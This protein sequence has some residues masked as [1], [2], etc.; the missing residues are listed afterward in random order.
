MDS[1][2][3]VE[4]GERLVIQMRDG[5]LGVSVTD[6]TEEQDGRREEGQDH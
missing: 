1:V 4:L 2:S 6:K 5:K 3:T